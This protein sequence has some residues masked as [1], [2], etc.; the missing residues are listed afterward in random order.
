M[1]LTVNLI[2]RVSDNPDGQ[3]AR[4]VRRL[5]LCKSSEK[6]LSGAGLKH[7]LEIDLG[8]AYRDRLN[9]KIQFFPASGVVEII[10]DNDKLTKKIVQTFREVI[11][12][13]FDILD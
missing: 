4:R 9:M 1:E 10:V 5:S 8:P 12:K 13:N 6:H 3:D 2:G 7:W 11:L